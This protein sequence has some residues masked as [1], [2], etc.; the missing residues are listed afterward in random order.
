MNEHTHY[1]LRK[2]VNSDESRIKATKEIFKSHSKLIIFYNFDYELEKRMK[3]A[4]LNKRE[5]IET[6]IDKLLEQEEKLLLNRI[7]K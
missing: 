4:E 1:L 3:R 5:I 2:V 7:K 6:D